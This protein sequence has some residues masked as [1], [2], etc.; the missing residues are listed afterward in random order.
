MRKPNLILFYSCFLFLFIACN[1]DDVIEKYPVVINKYDPSK[2]ISLD[3]ID[4]TYGIIDQVFIVY[5]NFPGKLSD[6]K[7]YFGKKRAIITATDGKSITGLIPKQVEGLNQISLVAGKDS[8]T[9]SGIL[10]KYKQSRSVKT[11]AGKLGTDKWLDDANYMG[12][13]I[14]AVTF[15]ETHYIATVAGHKY[16]NIIM[17][18]SGWGNRLF[19]LSQDDNKITKLSTPDK[20]CHPAVPSTRDRFYVVKF[21]GNNGDNTVYTYTKEDS[22]ALQTTGIIIKGDDFP[23]TKVPSITFAGDDNLLYLLSDEG[24]IAEVNLD[25]KSY[26]IYTTSTQ[27]PANINQDNFGGYITGVL[28][29]NFGDWEDSYI[30]YSKYHHCF[31][32][33]YTR[34]HAIFKYTK[35][36]DN[37]WTCSLYAGRN[38]QGIT[39]GN[40]LTDAKFNNPHG[41]IVNN[42]GEIFV[43]NKDGHCI[44]KIVDERVEIV[45]GRPGVTNPLV[46]GDP[47]LSTFNNPRDLAI[48]SEGNYFITGGND[49]TIRKLSIE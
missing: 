2:P 20:V 34:E 27:K 17:I 9:P 42:D 41:M 33:S 19:L 48:D 45:A 32:A 35:N 49:R 24:R 29:A 7:I 22:W 43:I 38:G 21:W 37:S 14:D 23:S 1:D 3:R 39:V 47:L 46:N 6:L 31:F 10:F 11:I 8:L 25:D 28:P 40:R 4:P 15:G 16:D 44:S 5:G 26:K 36:D 18:E 30:C 12:A 13:A